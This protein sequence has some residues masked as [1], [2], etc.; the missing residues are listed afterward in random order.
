MTKLSITLTILCS[1]AIGASGQT[2]VMQEEIYN[3]RD[4][5]MPALVHIQPVRKDY[6]TGELRKQEVIGSGVIFHPE[7]YVVT[8]YHVAGKAARIICTLHD[9]EQVPAIYVGGDPPTDI[10]V[11]K[12]DLEGYSGQISVGRVG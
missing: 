9:K 3:A 7:G 6:R 4:K 8:N 11:L 1:L 12:L 2:S 10:A 5:V